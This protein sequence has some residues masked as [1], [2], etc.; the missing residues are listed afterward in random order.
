MTLH[1]RIS[2]SRLF[3]ALAGEAEGRQTAFRPIFGAIRLLNNSSAF[4]PLRSGQGG[5][6][7][8]N[9][10]YFVEIVGIPKNRRSYFACFAEMPG[11]GRFWE[12]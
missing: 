11:F 10:V 12:R 5:H 1:S 8:K 7:S 3:E 6:R 2:C 9:F 4:L